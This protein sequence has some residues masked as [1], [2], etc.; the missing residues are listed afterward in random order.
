M[1]YLKTKEMFEDTKDNRRRIDNAI[2]N[3]KKDKQCSTKH[4]TEN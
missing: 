1:F 4:Y 2:A 3:M